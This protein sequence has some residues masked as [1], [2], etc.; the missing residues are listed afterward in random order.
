[1]KAP[2]SSKVSP[3]GSGPRVLICAPRARSKIL[4]ARLFAL[5][6]QHFGNTQIS[7]ERVCH[8]KP[9][10]AVLIG[11]WGDFKPLPALHECQIRFGVP[12]MVLVTGRQRALVPE[13]IRAGAADCLRWPIS[14]AEL[15]ARVEMRL[16]RA[17]PEFTLD[18]ASLTFRC[19]SVKVSLTLGEFH[20]LRYLLR[21]TASWSSSEK[22][23]NEALRSARPSKNQLRV[24]IYSI[25]R[26]LQQEAW[27]L[28]GHRSLG[29]RFDVNSSRSG[30]GTELAVNRE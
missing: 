12:V 26:K 21:A 3:G 18:A 30:E 9:E 5:L 16:V 11:G 2:E 7:T 25:R 15:L 20:I 17:P 19:H 10:L 14:D 29:Y 13:L 1:M 22:M 24:H 4:A 8:A 28:Q 23:T 27:R 6:A